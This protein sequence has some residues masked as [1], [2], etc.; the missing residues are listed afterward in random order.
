MQQEK[1]FFGIC[2]RVLNRVG[3]VRGLNHKLLGGVCVWQK[4]IESKTLSQMLHNDIVNC[5]HPL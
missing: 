3:N 5:S 2:G 4:I 1:I